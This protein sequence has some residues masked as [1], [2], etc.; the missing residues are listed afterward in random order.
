MVHSLV[1]IEN[2]TKIND[3]KYNLFIK[4]KK[5][6]NSMKVSELSP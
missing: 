4:N 5:N 6:I 2:T 3:S 1:D